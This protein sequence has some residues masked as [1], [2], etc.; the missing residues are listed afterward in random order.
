VRLYMRQLTS[1]SVNT[2]PAS[3]V[4]T[5][6]TGIPSKTAL[7]SM[8]SF[9]QL[10][11]PLSLLRTVKQK[12]SLDVRIITEF[13]GIVW[14][15][16]IRSAQNVQLPRKY[17]NVPRFLVVPVVPLVGKSAGKCPQNTAGKFLFPLQWKSAVKF[18]QRSVK[19]QRRNCRGVLCAHR[20]RYHAVTT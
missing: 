20:S 10:L 9:V 4:H 15:N 16:L 17:R 8:N 1:L 5:H 13:G 6:M 19:G 7:H 11:W 18:P 2:N 12:S 14:I 3:L